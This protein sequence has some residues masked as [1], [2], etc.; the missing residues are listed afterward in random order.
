MSTDGDAYFRS[1]FAIGD[2]G[3]GPGSS[4]YVIAEAGAN[5]NRDLGIAK[6]L[7]DVAADAGADAVKFQ[8][9]SGTALYSSKT[10]R[11]EYLKDE[12]SAAELLDAVALPR[13][14]QPELAAYARSRGIAFFSSPFDNDAVDTLSEIGVPALKI[15]S[16]ELIDLP[17][18]RYAASVGVPIILS[19]GMATYGEI[20]DALAAVRES[21]NREV[22]LLRCASLYPAPAEIMNIRAMA[23]MRDA[24]GV[25][26]G[27]SDHTTGISVPMGATALG[28]ELIEKHFT[29]S[30]NLEG[31]DHPFALEPGELRAMV[32]G[33]RDVEAAM[34]TGRLEGPS[35]AEAHEM[36]RLGRRSVVA[37]ADIPSGTMIT[38]EMLTTKRPGYG[39]KPKDL[40]LIVGRPARVDIEF[41][42]VITWEMV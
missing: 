21:G 25:P 5:H 8:T 30:R 1:T 39:I 23:T 3:V 11:F 32:A 12:R 15:A 26:V 31:P 24:F 37:A 6:E 29:L 17:L 19:T 10:P 16:F 28:T 7:V 14:W 9:Y 36:Y 40:D 20:E 42:D 33:V 38:R 34:G 18:I 27:L 2:R 13:E 22:A 41:D 4:V 35:D